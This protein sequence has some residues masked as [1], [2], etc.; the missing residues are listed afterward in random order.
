V[1]LIVPFKKV[2]LLSKMSVLSQKTLATEALLGWGTGLCKMQC[3]K[4]ILAPK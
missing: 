4:E 3:I 2:Q 1:Y